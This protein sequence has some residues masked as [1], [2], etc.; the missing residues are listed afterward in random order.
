[1]N[2]EYHR[3]KQVW[4]ML[5]PKVSVQIQPSE[6][7]ALARQLAARPIPEFLAWHAA[8]VELAFLAQGHREL[9]SPLSEW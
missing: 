1:M 5:K 2:A 6:S 9:A 7:L 3:H 4:Q 8:S